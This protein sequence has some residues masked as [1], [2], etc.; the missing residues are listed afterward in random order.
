MQE[1]WRSGELSRERDVIKLKE[2]EEKNHEK[3]ERKK[4]RKEERN[5]QDGEIIC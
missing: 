1:E 2:G 5:I 3:K 4:E